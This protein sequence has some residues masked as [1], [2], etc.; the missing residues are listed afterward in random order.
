M[1]QCI[2]IRSSL[3]ALLTAAVTLNIGCGQSGPPT[4]EIHGAVHYDGKPIPVGT[5]TLIPDTPTGRTVVAKIESGQYVAELTEGT[6]TVNVQA[7]RETGP[8]IPSLGEAPREQYIPSRY[9]RDSTLKVTA[10]PGNPE[11]NFELEAA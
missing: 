3:G 5:L 8:V 2:R 10:P 6:W 1:R 11:Q 4:Y 7:V 9:N